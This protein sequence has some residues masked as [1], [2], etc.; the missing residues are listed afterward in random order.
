MSFKLILFPRWVFTEYQ[1]KPERLLGQRKVSE[2]FR[3]GGEERRKVE[4]LA[5]V[6]QAVPLNL[7]RGTRNTYCGLPG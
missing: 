5:E 6:L 1:R 4:E 2:I 7:F 3:L